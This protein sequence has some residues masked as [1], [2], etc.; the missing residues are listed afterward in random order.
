[1]AIRG[2]VVISIANPARS[3]MNLLNRVHFSVVAQAPERGVRAGSRRIAMHIDGI[4]L[5][6]LLTAAEA[7]QAQ[8]EGAPL[9]AGN[10]V[11]PIGDERL[12]AILEGRDEPPGKP[13]TARKQVGAAL[14]NC[15]C[16][17]EDCWPLAMRVQFGARVVTWSN[18]CQLRRNGDGQRAWSYAELG[19]FK[20][21]RTQYVAAMAQI[22]GG[23]GWRREALGRKPVTGA[24]ADVS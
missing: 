12:L 20:F 18:F 24:L 6:D 19:S 16:G 5:I 3:S 9:L 10:Y 14:L 22:S 1:M 8:R 13:A 7:G 4:S 11:W 15:G 2:L 21:D 17:Y 23:F